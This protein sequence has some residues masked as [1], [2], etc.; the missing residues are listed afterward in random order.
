L[1]FFCFQPVRFSSALGQGEKARPLGLPK[2]WCSLEN[3]GALET[4]AIRGRA[5]LN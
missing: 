5:A 3:S 4:A 2:K 1:T